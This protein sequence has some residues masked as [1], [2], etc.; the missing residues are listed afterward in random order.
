MNKIKVKLDKGAFTPTRAYPTDAGLDLRTPIGFSVLPHSMRVIDTGVHIEIPEGFYGALRSKSGLMTKKRI[1][2]DGTIDAGYN[3]SIAVA[4]FNHSEELAIFDE[5]DKVAQLVIQPCETPEV[6]IVDELTET[7]RG[8]KG[9]G[10]S[11]R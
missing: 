9:F 4:L 3:G 2:T 7:E 1:T 6:E 11:G 8:E 5:G 10:S